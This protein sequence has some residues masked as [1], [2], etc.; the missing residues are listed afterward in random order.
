MGAHRLS[1]ATKLGRVEGVLRSGGASW[2][3]APLTW[4]ALP[5]TNAHVHCAATPARA[6]P[7]RDTKD[8]P[9]VRGNPKPPRKTE[10]TIPNAASSNARDERADFLGSQGTRGRGRRMQQSATGSVAGWRGCAGDNEAIACACA[11]THNAWHACTARGASHRRCTGRGAP[12]GPLT[13]PRPSGPGRWRR[14]GGPAPPHGT[15]A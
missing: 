4:A 11:F 3:M 14:R 8:I 1:S 12:V 9:A 13:R 15:T 10:S 5:H 2:F 6:R 7:P